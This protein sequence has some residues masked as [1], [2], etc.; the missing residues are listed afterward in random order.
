M[1]TPRRDG[2]DVTPSAAWVRANDD[3]DSIKACVTMHDIDWIWHKYR[4]SEDSIGHRTVSHVM[5]IEEKS[6]NCDLTMPQ[7]E[8]MYFLDQVLQPRRTYR[9]RSPRGERIHVR[10]WGYFKLRYDGETLPESETIWWNKREIGLDTLTRILRF[11]LD[12]RTLAERDDRRH[13]TARPRPLE[14][15]FG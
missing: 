5:F 1:T 14:I 4:I 3:L 9:L 15:H 2:R 7:R 8:I 6:C 11:D 10:F 12:P 13:H